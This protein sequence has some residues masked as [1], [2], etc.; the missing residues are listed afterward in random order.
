MKARHWILALVLVAGGAFAVG[1]A[2]AGDEAKEGMG[3]DE[4]WAKYSAPGPQHAHLKRLAGTWNAAVDFGGQKG[5]GVSVNEMVLGDR[6]LKQTYTDKSGAF[7]GIGFTGFDNGSNKIVVT[8][9]DSMGTGIQ[10]TTGEIDA[11]GKVVTTKGE[12]VGPGGKP[13]KIRTKSTIA[14]DDETTYEQWMA[15][16]DGP[17]QKL[18]HIVYTR[19][20]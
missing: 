18:L 4:A 14:S 19:Q 13:L 17:E 20:K 6:F 10:I 16:G 2:R 3:M 5:E 12:M 8:W 11:A 9:M 15:E 7:E 1:R